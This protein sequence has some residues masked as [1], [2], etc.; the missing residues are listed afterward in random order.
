MVLNYINKVC[1]HYTP[2][3]FIKKVYLT[4]HNSKTDHTTPNSSQTIYTK[5]WANPKH[6]RSS[7]L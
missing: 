6:R 5:Q 3:H 7:L 4:L 2:Q 1:M